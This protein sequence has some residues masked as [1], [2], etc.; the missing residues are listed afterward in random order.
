MWQLLQITKGNGHYVNIKK[1]YMGD[2][3][4]QIE[5]GETPIEAAKKSYISRYNT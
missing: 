3:R 1:E 5:Q 4:G 2:I